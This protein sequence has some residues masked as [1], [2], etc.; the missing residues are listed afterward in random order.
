MKKVLCAVLTA[1]LACGLCGCGKSEKN[2]SLSESSTVPE[3]TVL[4]VPQGYDISV[5]SSEANVDNIELSNELSYEI[6]L[7][8][9]N[10]TFPCTMKELE[11]IEIGLGTRLTPIKLD[12]G[13][14]ADHFCMTYNGENVGY[15][16]I[17]IND[18]TE[19][20][21][22][23]VVGIRIINKD[24]EIPVSYR[25][26]TI[27]SDEQD[28]LNEL[29]EPDKNLFGSV[30]SYFIASEGGIMFRYNDERKVYEIWLRTAVR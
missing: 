15:I 1:A 13:G 14:S 27:G 28:I 18:I 30:S 19:L 17:E 26:F 10:I 25:G 20:S 2:N 4:S 8:G 7:A 21:E 29:G 24:G 22:R 16:D 6:E 3:N 9:H 12:N 5:T 23:T 11:N